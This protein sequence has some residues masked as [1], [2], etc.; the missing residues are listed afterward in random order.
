MGH[1]TLDERVMDLEEAVKS[2]DERIFDLAEG[3]LWL[4]GRMDSAP[5]V[6]VRTHRRENITKSRTVKGPQVRK[7][8]VPKV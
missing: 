6:S 8:F 3:V 4:K 5:L 7:G 2:L 1:K